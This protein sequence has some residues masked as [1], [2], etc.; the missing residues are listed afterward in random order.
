MTKDTHTLVKRIN[1]VCSQKGYYPTR[2][3]GHLGWNRDW[4]LQPLSGLPSKGPPRSRT[5]TSFERTSLG[6]DDRSE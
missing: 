3:T 6:M 5:S 2:V 1:T 4:M